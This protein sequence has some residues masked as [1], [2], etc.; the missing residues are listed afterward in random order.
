MAGTLVGFILPMRRGKQAMILGECSLRRAQS[1]LFDFVPGAIGGFVILSA[2]EALQV[3]FQSQMTV[4][5][6][7]LPPAGM[8]RDM[9]QTSSFQ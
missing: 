7:T 9:S 5:Q 6:S 2:I 8:P 4:D 3:Y 1:A